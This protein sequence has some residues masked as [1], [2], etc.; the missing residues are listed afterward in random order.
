M[1]YFLLKSGFDN[2]SKDTAIVIIIIMLVHKQ[3]LRVQRNLVLQF[4]LFR[5]AEACNY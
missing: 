2:T 3:F 5:Q 4:D 1:V